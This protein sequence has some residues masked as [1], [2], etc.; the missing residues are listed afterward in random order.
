MAI[1][2][3]SICHRICQPGFASKESV[4]SC[5]VPCTEKMISGELAG[6]S[7]DAADSVESGVVVG[8]GGVEDDGASGTIDGVVTAAATGL[9]FVALP[10]HVP[11]PNPMT[12]ATAS[13]TAILGPVK[14]IPPP[15]TVRPAKP[16]AANSDRPGQ[17]VGA[18]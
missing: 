5:F 7:L 4:T 9:V 17:T 13:K 3:P 11:S 18:S 8:E 15:S 2:F 1:A 16:A 10:S 14:E 6:A 12:P